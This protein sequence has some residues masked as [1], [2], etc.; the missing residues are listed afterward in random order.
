MEFFCILFQIEKDILNK[1]N[2]SWNFTIYF[3]KLNLCAALL[4]QYGKESKEGDGGD[5][6]YGFLEAVELQLQVIGKYTYVFST[7]YT[8]SLFEIEKIKLAYVVCV[9]V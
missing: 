7:C 4:F 8:L 6:K 3:F 2:L 9:V 1:K 5:G